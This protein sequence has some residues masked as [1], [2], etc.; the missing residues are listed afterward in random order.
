MDYDVEKID[1]VTLALLALSIHQE[2]EHGARVWKG[3][4]WDTMNRLREKGYI[5][6]PVGRARSMIV[7]PEG[8]RKAREFFEKHFGG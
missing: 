2:S 5:D 3:F 1:E 8:C 4:D 6:D 7:T